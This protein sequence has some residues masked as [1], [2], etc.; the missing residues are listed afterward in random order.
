MTTTI[1]RDKAYDAMKAALRP[2]KGTLKGAFRKQ[3]ALL[4]KLAL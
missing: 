3:P 4:A 2:S 1:E